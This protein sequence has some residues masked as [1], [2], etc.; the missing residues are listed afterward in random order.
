MSQIVG[1]LGKEDNRPFS[2]DYINF[3]LSSFFFFLLLK[4]NPFNSRILSIFF[5]FILS[6]LYNSLFE[7][8]L[9]TQ[10][11]VHDGVRILFRILNYV[12]SNEK[13]NR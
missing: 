11:G 8:N 6:I 4:S 7:F 1:V 5:R 13:N 2:F 10:M 12:S 3:S 9:L